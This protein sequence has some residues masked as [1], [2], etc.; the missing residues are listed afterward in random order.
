MPY[1]FNDFYLHS[2]EFSGGPVVRTRH[3]HIAMAWVRLGKYRSSSHAIWPKT[4]NIMCIQIFSEN[5]L[6]G[7]IG[8]YNPFSWDF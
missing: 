1:I 6:L 3:F 7:D 8:F 4:K 2:W 5:K